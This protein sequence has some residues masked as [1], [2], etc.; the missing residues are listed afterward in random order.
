MSE[1]TTAPRWWRLDPASQVEMR[2]DPTD[3][4]L[5]RLVIGGY[6]HRLTRPAIVMRTY[7]DIGTHREYGAWEQLDL[8]KSPDGARARLVLIG[9]DRLL[10]VYAEVEPHIG[11]WTAAPDPTEE[12]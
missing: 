5:E 6:P 12:S 8:K 2:V 9:D 11:M 10:D 7:S 4:E 1:T 3:D